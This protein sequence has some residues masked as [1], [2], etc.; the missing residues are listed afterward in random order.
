MLDSL[1]YH[2]KSPFHFIKTGL[3]SGLTSQILSGFP[4]KRLK[5]YC[6]TGTD[7]KTTSSSLL[8]HVLKQQGKKVAL[9]STVAAYIGEEKIETGFHVTTPNP[10]AL[11]QLFKRLVHDKYE[12]VVLE[13]TS[14]G[15]YQQRLWGIRPKVLGVTNITHEHLDYHVTYDNYVQAK[16]GLAL[17]SKKIILNSDDGSYSLLKKKLSSVASRVSSYSLEDPLPKQVKLAIDKRFPQDYNKMNARM[18]YAMSLAIGVSDEIFC[19]S[20][21]S[22]PS[23]PGRMEL[24]A[25][26]NN[27]K[28]YVDFAHTPNALEKVLGA[29]RLE[30]KSS[31][32]SGRLIAVFG[33]TGER[34]RRKRPKMGLIGSS[35]ADVAIFTADDT[36][37]E[38]IWSIIRQMKEGL[39]T[40]LAK[41]TSIAD[42]RAAIEWA[43]LH[44][45][46][47]GDIV[48][49]LGKGHEQTILHGTTEYPWSDV[50]VAREILQK[51]DK[52]DNSINN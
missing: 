52:Y 6:V 37:S 36:R 20:L 22:F 24:A 41:V 28:V 18:V 46:K 45:A 34:D 15:I 29:L 9:I 50:T 48:A 35:L 30:L 32:S 4:E 51:W 10:K 31:S 44:I 39:T 3:L 2:L 7:G 19:Q 40:T 21:S 49:L 33:C 23:V 8:F 11:Y 25:K 27:L 5:F 26:K 43:I 47:P 1:I 17:R 14:H 38:D 12:A 42:R 13:A 16:A